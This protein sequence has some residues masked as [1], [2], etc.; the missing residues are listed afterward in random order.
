MGGMQRYE[1]TWAVL[2]WG[3]VIERLWTRVKSEEGS[4]RLRQSQL[5]FWRLL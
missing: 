1:D 4:S 5:G 2:L 3:E